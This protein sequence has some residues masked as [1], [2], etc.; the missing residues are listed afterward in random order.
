MLFL[1]IAKRNE[2]NLQKMAMIYPF[3]FI[4]AASKQSF[5]FALFRKYILTAVISVVANI[6]VAQTDFTA[7]AVPDSVFARM[8]GVSFPKKQVAGLGVQR[9]DLRYLQILHYDYEG[10][11]TRGELICNK[12]IAADLLDIFRQL[13]EA[14]YPIASVR[15][16]DDFGAD[17]ERSMRAN[18]TSC[19]CFRAVAGSS[20][21]SKHAQGLAIDLNPLENPC[22]KVRS[23]RTI[24]QPSTGKAF[25]NRGRSFAHKIDRSDLAYRLFTQHGFRW[26]GSWRSLKDYQHFEK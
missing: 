7:T 2:K 5:M 20:K 23:G 9:S 25:V 15:L 24:V 14:H 10:Q 12:S 6:T 3:L 18:N 16:I 13:F 4:F 22:V 26:G 21:L 19:F 8:I 1:H 11:I 17:D